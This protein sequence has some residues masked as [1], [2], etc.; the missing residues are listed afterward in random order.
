MEALADAEE[1]AVRGTGIF[2]FFFFFVKPNY[3]LQSTNSNVE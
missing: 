3:N 1:D 2:F